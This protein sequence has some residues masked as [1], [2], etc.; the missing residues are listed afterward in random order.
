VPDRRRAQAFGL[1]NIGVVVGQGAALLLAGA[2]AEVMPP[3][4]VIAVGGGIGA[5]SACGLARRW[6]HI[7]PAVGRHTARHLSRQT[8]RTSP[9]RS[10]VTRLSAATAPEKEAS[11]KAA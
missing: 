8:S 10:Q 3:A 4:T 9:K 6:R 7:P 11:E 1:A 2:A 5:L